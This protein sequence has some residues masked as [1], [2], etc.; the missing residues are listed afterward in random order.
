MEINALPLA[1]E[2]DGNIIPTVD[3]RNPFVSYDLE[4]KRKILENTILAHEK[5]CSQFDF[6]QNLEEHEAQLV[7]K[8]LN[9]VIETQIEYYKDSIVNYDKYH[10]ILRTVPFAQIPELNYKLQVAQFG[11]SSEKKN[12]DGDT[13]KKSSSERAR[14]KKK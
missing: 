1:L 14:K 2:I 13:K 11:G 7:K 8:S 10:K 6:S 12:Q 4:Q 3:S 9:S 5:L